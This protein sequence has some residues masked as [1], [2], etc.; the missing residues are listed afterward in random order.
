MKKTTFEAR[1]EPTSFSQLVFANKTDFDDLKFYA[2][3]RRYGHLFFYGPNGSG[4][5]AAAQMIVSER[6]RLISAPNIMVESFNGG[7]RDLNL[8]S[9]ISRFDVLVSPCIGGDDEPYI[10][11]DEVH[12]LTKNSQSHLQYLMDTMVVGKFIL[13]SN[14]FDKVDLGIRDRSNKFEILYPSHEQWL[15]RARAIMIAEGFNVS[16]AELID[17]LSKASHSGGNPTIRE[18][19]GS[20]DELSVTWKG[21]AG[22]RKPV[23]IAVTAP[24]APKKK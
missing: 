3:R 15:P 10:I 22:S 5:T 23:S 2:D 16:D 13:T 8:N 20:L 1:H 4:K 17:V 14:D 9:I 24:P 12:K 21:N 18:M 19:L 7:D 11:I 6:Q